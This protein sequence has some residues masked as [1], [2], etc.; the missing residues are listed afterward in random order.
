MSYT[1]E[2]GE[3]VVLNQYQAIDTDGF[4]HT[5]LAQ[6]AI[7]AMRIIRGEQPRYRVK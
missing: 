3:K 6:N 2:N 4:V 7:E 1:L 5:V